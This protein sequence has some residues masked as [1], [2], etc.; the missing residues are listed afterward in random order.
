MLAPWIQATLETAG[1]VISGT[2]AEGAVRSAAEGRLHLW[3][4]ISLGDPLFL[5]LLPLALAL[6]LRRH[7]RRRRP[8][9][10][11]PVLPTEPLP[12]S[13]AQRLAWVPP[14]AGVLAIVL[15]I[16]AL[17]R[18]L[19]GN[20]QL[21]SS[22]EGIDIA[23]LVDRSSSMQ[24][25]DLSASRTR[26]DVVRQVV[27]DF[28]QRRMTD[29]EGASDH[30]ALI[31]FARYPSLLC[32]FTLD[33]DAIRGFLDGVKIVQTRDED[34]TAIGVALAKAVAVLRESEAASRVVVLLTDG[35][36]NIDTITPAQ[37]AT[38]AAEEKIR[39]YTILAGRF[40]YGYDWAGRVR[41]TNQKIDT[42]ELEAIA[43]ETG[44]R[45]FRAHDLDELEDVY[46]EIEALERTKR[47]EQ[48]FVEAFDL[49]PPLLMGALLLYLFSW[50]SSA[51]WARRIL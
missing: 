5:L 24:H 14:T 51:T 18:P 47:E 44:G 2:A 26:L 12:R 22:A 37:A 39:V 49:Y 9:A 23:L 42:R 34:G 33:V 21:T 1:G 13:L 36:N 28:A 25:D 46:I 27:G 32:P 35:E 19:R 48:R 31:T 38:F 41:P 7:A 8:A 10:V 15:V 20:V 50:F 6:I 4:N 17:A 29:R 45:F 30:V 40:V 43:R 3:G 11:L 16:F